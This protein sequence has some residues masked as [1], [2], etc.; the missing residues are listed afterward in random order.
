MAA[1]TLGIP[2]PVS[3]SYCVPNLTELNFVDKALS[4]SGAKFTIKDPQGNLLFQVE[5]QWP[6]RQS[7]HIV[8]DSSEKALVVLTK[9]ER[10]RHD[11]WEATRANG[12]QE[13]VFVMKLSSLNP[14]HTN[15]DVFMGR[16][17]STSRPEF[18]VKSDIRKFNYT[19]CHN[20]VPIAQATR[21]LKFGK[22]QYIAII[23][24][25][26]DIAFIAMLVVIIMVN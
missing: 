1:S 7:K 9:E 17:T 18:T 26:V 15:F 5:D 25:G 11:T 14:L 3:T 21:R 13:T 4:F 16:N 23:K 12:D 2:A 22:N 19:I 6:S 24:P 8:C 10:T 20:D